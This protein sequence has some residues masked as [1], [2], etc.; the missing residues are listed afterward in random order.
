VRADGTLWAWGNNGAG[1][2]GL[3]H[4]SNTNTPQ[5]VGAATNWVRVAAG[6]YHTVGIRA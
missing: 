1:Q 6:A 2:L 5:Q 4:N 3:G